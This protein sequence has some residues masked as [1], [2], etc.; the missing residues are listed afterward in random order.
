MG[1]N[2][3]RIGINNQALK[4]FNLNRDL[5][6]LLRALALR[7]KLFTSPRNGLFFA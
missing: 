1:I 4:D 6:H 2:S 7:A 3:P 5:S